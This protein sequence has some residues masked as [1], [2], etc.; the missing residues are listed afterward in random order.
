[1]G[2]AEAGPGAADRGRDHL[3]GLALAD[4]TLVQA[5]LHVDELRDLALEQARNGN[6]GPGGDDGGDIVG[7]DLLLEEHGLAWR[8]DRLLECGELLL[9]LQG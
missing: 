8:G 5:R 6:P 2:S 3:D 7:V 4:D 9:E 1:M